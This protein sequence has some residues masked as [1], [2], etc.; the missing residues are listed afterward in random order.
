ME[1]IST[2]NNTTYSPKAGEIER[3]IVIFHK[4][5]NIILDFLVDLY[6]NN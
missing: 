5:M 2:M 6:Q 1:G 3:K 4:K